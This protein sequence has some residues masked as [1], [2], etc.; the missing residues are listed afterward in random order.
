MNSS[1]NNGVTFGSLT[2]ATFGGLTGSSNLLLQ[3]SSNAAVALTTGAN[4]STYSG[5]LSGSGSLIKGGGGNLILNGANSYTGVTQ[6][7]NGTLTIGATG[8]IAQSPTITVASG[9]TFAAASTLTIGGTTAQK[10]QGTG[11]TTGSLV[12]GSNGT[13]RGDSGTG[14]GTLTTGNVLLNSG[15]TFQAA[16]GASGTNSQIALGANTLEFTTNSKLKLISNGGFTS[17]PFGPSQTYILATLSNGANL[18]LDGAT[19]A[20]G[21]LVGS[22]RHGTGNSGAVNFDVSGLTLNNDDIFLVNRNGNNLVLSF[23]PVPEP[24][25]ILTGIALGGGLLGY[26]RRRFKR[27]VAVS[28]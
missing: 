20:D 17:T 7:T 2:A 19:V 16:I 12:I 5:I 27:T 10:L 1:V 26:A 18:K 13:I 28:A 21:G 11:N 22:Y 25:S 3:N 6:V 9:G 14:T 15:G 4:T 24:V 8:S 23:T